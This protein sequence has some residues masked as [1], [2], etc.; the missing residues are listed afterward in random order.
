MERIFASIRETGETLRLGRTTIY[1][2]ISEGQLE[3]VKLGRRTLIRLSSIQALAERGCP[4][5]MTKK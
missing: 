4:A 2:L 5:G 3:K 1:R